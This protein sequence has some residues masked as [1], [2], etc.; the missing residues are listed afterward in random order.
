MSFFLLFL[1]DDASAS[2][3]SVACVAG[4]AAL[5]IFDSLLTVEK[6]NA[7]DNPIGAE[8]SH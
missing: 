6:S 7:N 4:F 1:G 5:A 3:G 2:S 8:I